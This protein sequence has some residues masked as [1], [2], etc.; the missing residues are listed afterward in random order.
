[1]L[2]TIV[3]IPTVSMEPERKPE[4]RK[5][6]SVA[7]EFLRSLGAEA[8]ICETAGNPV[9]VGRFQSSNARRTVTIY[10]HLDVQPAQEPEWTREPF[11]FVKVDGRYLGRGT[12]DDKGPALTAL[13]GAR[14]AME[15]GIPLNIQFVW[16]LEE[17]IGSPHFEEFLKANHQRLKTD[18][19][20]VSDTMWISRETPAIPYGLRGMVTGTM[21]LETHSKDTHSGVTGGAA[22]NPLAELA[23][24][25]A[26]LHDARTGK[27]KIPGFYKDVLPVS[28]KEMEGF[29]SSGFNIKKWKQVYGFK[30]LRTD[31]VREVLR[32][33][34]CMPTFEVHGMVGGYTGPGVKTIVPP[35]AE[36]KFSTRLV[37]KQNPSKILKMIRSQVR[38]LNPDVKVHLEA[39]LDP[40][41]GR[42]SGSYVD[43]ATEAVRY[44]FSRFLSAKED[45]SAQWLPWKDT[46]ESRSSLSA[47][48][49]R[50]MDIMLPM[51]IMIGDRLPAG[52]R[53][54]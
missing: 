1:M 5:G 10:N 29:L 25:V 34:W 21:T 51:R 42:L 23:Q 14:Y 46:G 6:A 30:S 43:A 27:V 17:E 11:I 9:V 38:K 8:E 41:L 13:L 53:R 54:L 52:S 3:E 33:V 32:R 19:V 50:N 39:S 4:I 15:N 37:P 45:P 7:V 22:R 16:E 49:C 47:S 18:S 36:L 26:Q 31:N 2:G 35:R 40:Y 12:T 28:K 24:L 44:G 48:L 20:L